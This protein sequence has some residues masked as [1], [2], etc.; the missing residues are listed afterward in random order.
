MGCGLRLAA[1]LVVLLQAAAAIAVIL[2][3]AL[4]LNKVD[5]KLTAGTAPE[6]EG[7]IAAALSALLPQATVTDACLIGKPP[8]NAEGLP[9]VPGA[10]M[11]YYAFSVGGFSLLATLALSILQCVT[12]QLCG[13]GPILDAVF[14]L[15]GAA[16]WALA[17][18]LFT[19]TR[20]APYNRLLPLPEWREALVVVCWV[21]CGLFALWFV[22]SVARVRG[23]GRRG[24][25][26]GGARGAAARRRGA[27]GRRRPCSARA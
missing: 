2:M 20:D 25:R 6:G 9:I 13:L 14:A 7:G 5:F 17:G 22:I 3:T 16:W 12:C 26:R 23:G 19:Q 11:C 27:G 4:K 18:V 8:P 10:N 1:G 24:R 15:A 21:G